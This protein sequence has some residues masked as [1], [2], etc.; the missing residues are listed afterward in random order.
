MIVLGWDKTHDTIYK[1]TMS[2]SEAKQ[3]EGIEIAERPSSMP[4]C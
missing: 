1:I 2:Q 4:R 3:K